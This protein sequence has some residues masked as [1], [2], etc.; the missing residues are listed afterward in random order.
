[1]LTPEPFL[2]IAW[3]DGGWPGQNWT[4]DQGD[5]PNT[6]QFTNVNVDGFGRGKEEK[7]S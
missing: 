6:V 2:G 7:N 1:M 4:W 3:G 5:L